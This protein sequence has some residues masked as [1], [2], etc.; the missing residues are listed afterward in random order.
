MDS[1]GSLVSKYSGSS[2]A[3]G[4]GTD[5]ASTSVANIKALLHI[6]GRKCR[7]I[8]VLVIIVTVWFSPG[9]Q[10]AGLQT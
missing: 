2:C 5:G 8:S 6:H 1:K 4:M 10:Y 3:K 9:S 7:N